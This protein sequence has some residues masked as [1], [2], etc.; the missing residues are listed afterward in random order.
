M[1]VMVNMTE[2]VNVVEVVKLVEKEKINLVNVMAEWMVTILG[3]EGGF[4]VI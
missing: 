2:V 3:L 1:M 4:S